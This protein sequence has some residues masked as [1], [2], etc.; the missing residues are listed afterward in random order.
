MP[1]AWVLNFDAERELEANGSPSTPSADVRARMTNL[2]SCVGLLSEGDIVL[3]SG[4]PIA[5]GERY[6]G[7]AWC[8][9]PTALDAM[10]RAGVGVPRAPAFHVLRRVNARRFASELGQTLPGALYATTLAEV[11]DAVARDTISGEWL[12]KRA[13][14]FAGRGRR[15]VHQGELSPADR[16][17]V[18]ASL[19]RSDGLQVE[20]WVRR[21]AD[22]ALHGFVD[23]R[24]ELRLGEVTRQVCNE[25]GAWCKTILASPADLDI[26]ERRALITATE[27]AAFALVAEGYF[28]PF[29]VDAFRWHDGKTSTAFNARSEINAR[30]SMGWAHGMGGHSRWLPFYSSS[31]D[32]RDADA[33]AQSP[34]A[35]G[36]N[37]A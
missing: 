1:R 28:G 10:A 19:A 14:G 30:F 17:W 31:T 11:A 34:C 32:I 27:A 3:G 26:A 20:P 29:G 21:A 7:M 37:E 16:S 24:G 13:F 36:S 12:L 15:K 6:A 33:P 23:D 8:P 25:H 9:T 18:A 22:F 5:A 4:K 2:A 35:R